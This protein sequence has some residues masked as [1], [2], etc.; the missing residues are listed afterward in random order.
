MLGYF[1][2]PTPDADFDRMAD[3]WEI[4]DF[5]N[6]GVSDGGL[7]EDYDNDRFCDLREFLAGTIPT[8]AASNGSYSRHS[9][10]T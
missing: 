4:L 3:Q 6:T 7:A 10:P 2:D 1:C 9:R 8:N 5:G